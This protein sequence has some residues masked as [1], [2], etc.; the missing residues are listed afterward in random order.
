MTQALLN[1]LLNAVQ[2]IEAEGNI[3][4]GA[5]LYEHGTRLNIWVESDGPSIPPEQRERIFDPFFTTRK[6]GTGLG[7]AIVHKIVENHGGEIILESPLPD[8]DHGCR[9][10]IIIP[11]DVDTVHSQKA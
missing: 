5:N 8:K 10:T 3:E 7:L 6:K 4:V 9:F 2:A 1:L 11:I